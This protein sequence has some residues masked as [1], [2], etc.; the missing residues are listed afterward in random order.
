MGQPLICCYNT[1]ISSKIRVK[2]NTITHKYYLEFNSILFGFI[3]IYIYLCENFILLTHL[4][5]L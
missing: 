2:L 1:T 3:Y 5:P 4:K